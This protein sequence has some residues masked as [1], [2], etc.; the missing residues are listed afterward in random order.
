MLGLLG[1]S[2]L[3]F[4]GGI[5]AFFLQR[6]D[7]ICPNG[8]PPVSQRSDVIGPTEYRCSNGLVVTK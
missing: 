2:V 6:N 4:A 1:I 7:T 3:L 5:L 8:K